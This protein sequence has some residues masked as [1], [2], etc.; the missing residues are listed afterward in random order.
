[1][2]DLEKYIIEFRDKLDTADPP[3]GHLDRFNRKLKRDQQPIRRVNFRHVLQVAAS[4]AVII[5]STVVIV[6]TGKGGNKIAA[7]PAVEQF[8]E[9]S[10]FYARQVSEK[11]EDIASFSFDSELEKEMLMEELGE[12]DKYYKEL[13]EEL[14]ANPGDERVMSALIRH[15]QIKLQVMDQ[16][17][18]QLIQIN[19]TNIDENEK[20][21]V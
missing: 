15:Y 16:I 7:H 13:L 12:M 19:N 11:Q 8:Q 14:N 3:K 18:D 17:I 4:V 5:T 20:T 6:K 21:D 10:N 9:T 1:M 2:S